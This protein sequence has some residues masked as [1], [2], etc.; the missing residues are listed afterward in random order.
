MSDDLQGIS[1][2]VGK[3]VSKGLIRFIGKELITNCTVL[4]PP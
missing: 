1:K 3:A 4:T 2:A